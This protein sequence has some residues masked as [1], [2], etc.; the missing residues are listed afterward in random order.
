MDPNM[1]IILP[2]MTPNIF[3]S[4]SSGSSTEATEKQ[5]GPKHSTASKEP[6]EED[7]WSV[8]IRTSI[9]DAMLDHLV[10]GIIFLPKSWS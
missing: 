5:R 6:K 3:D 4:N 1:E 7:Q 8:R 9:K 10:K 2:V